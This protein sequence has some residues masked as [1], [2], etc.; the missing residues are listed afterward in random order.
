MDKTITRLRSQIKKLQSQLDRALVKH[1]SIEV[2]RIVQVM[3]G[4]S[5]TPDDIRQALESAP[6]AKRAQKM[7]RTDDARR[8]APVAPKYRDQATG[9][10]WTG[11]GKPPRWL[12]AA[13][14]AGTSREAF[15]IA[16]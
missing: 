10:T 11:R 5:L 8:R 13:E 1:R 6:K 15:L 16:P 14:R 3:R 2:Q 9:D 7:P 12:S 4:H